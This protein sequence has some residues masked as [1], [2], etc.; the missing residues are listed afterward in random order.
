MGGIVPVYRYAV[1]WVCCKIVE[2]TMS[3]ARVSMH[4]CRRS[5]ATPGEGKGRVFWVRQSDQNVDISASM[6]TSTRVAPTTTAAVA[7]AAVAMAW[8]AAVRVLFWLCA[9]F[10][11]GGKSSV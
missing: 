1:K 9:E 6:M 7:A 2:R 3:L 10:D 5:Q 8:R 11:L 4:C